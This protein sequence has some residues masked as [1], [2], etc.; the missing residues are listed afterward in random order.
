[1]SLSLKFPELSV[2]YWGSFSQQ[3]GFEVKCGLG[4][5]HTQYRLALRPFDGELTRRPAADWTATKLHVQIRQ[6]TCHLYGVE[7]ADGQVEGEETEDVSF[8]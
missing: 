6:I 2:W 4:S 5:L 1:M 8:I 3:R 7:Q